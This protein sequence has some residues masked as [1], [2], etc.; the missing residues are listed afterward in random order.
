MDGAG[1][2]ALL[3]GGGPVFCVERIPDRSA[4]AAAMCAGRTTEAEGI[5]LEA[6]VSGVAGLRGG[7]GP[8]SLVASVA[9]GA[10][11]ESVVGVCY[12][13]GELPGAVSGGEG[14]FACLVVVCGGAFLFDFA[15]A[16]GGGVA[17]A[18][19]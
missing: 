9:G 18:L 1:G 8:L 3:G 13:Y 4:V 2:A 7:G 19:K 17:A 16:G 10:E 15:A 11:D 12:V 14:V 6:P 5:F